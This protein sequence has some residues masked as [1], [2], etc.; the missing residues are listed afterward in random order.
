MKINRKYLLYVV[1]AIM[2]LSG[3]HSEVE[4]HN[5]VR[6]AYIA[7]IPQKIFH[8]IIR[9]GIN[10]AASTNQVHIDFYPAQNQRDV[11]TQKRRLQEISRSKN[12]Q[13]VLLAPNDSKALLDDIRALDRAGIWFMIVDT[14]LVDPY[15]NGMTHNCGFVGTDNILAGRMAAKFIKLEMD[16]GNILMM[17]GNH[18]QKSSIDRERGFVEQIKKYNQ[19]KIVSYLSG[20]WEMEP[21]VDAMSRYLK[22]NSDLPDAIFAYSDT[23]AVAISKY[24]ESIGIKK[25]PIIVGV[26]GVMLGQQAILEGKID[27]SV[28]QAP[29]VMGEKAL[30]YLLKCIRE[31][32]SEHKEILTPV[33][34]LKASRTLEVINP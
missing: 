14:P 26:D 10:K 6:I 33:T 22:H 13:G 5:S 15:I 19:F 7:K 24:F 3:C 32:C 30:L 17:R 25:R 12:Y 29:E 16:G 23:M 8:D 4:K 28:V 34:L 21:T 31:N 18:E 9:H 27:A 11:E 1:S 20:Y 2:I